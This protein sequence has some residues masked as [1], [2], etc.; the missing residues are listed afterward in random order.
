MKQCNDRSKEM[1]TKR[2]MKHENDKRRETRQ[3][4][5][6]NIL[7]NIWSGSKPFIKVVLKPKTKMRSCLRTTL[8]NFFDPL[9]M[10]TTDKVKYDSEWWWNKTKEERRWDKTKW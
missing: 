1:E 9:Q 7:V 6:E 3:Q 5:R 2:E 10:L 8:M 4:Y